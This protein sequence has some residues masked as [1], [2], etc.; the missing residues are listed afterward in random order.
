M[1]KNY[2][3]GGDNIVTE[4]FRDMLYNLYKKGRASWDD[5]DKL[6]MKTISAYLPTAVKKA[7]KGAKLKVESFDLFHYAFIVPSE[8]EEEIRDDIIRPIFVQSSLISN[9]DHKDRL[10]FL[11]DIE[12]IFYNHSFERGENTILCRI[13]HDKGKAVIKFDLI[14]TT[15]T[16]FNFPNARFFPKVTK[17]GSVS[18]TADDIEGHIKEFLRKK[19]FSVATG[20]DRHMEPLKEF[21]KIELVSLNQDSNIE[22][23]I[24]EIMSCISF[25][26]LVI[27]YNLI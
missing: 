6:L 17:S 24:K 16:L 5:E 23:V 8:W 13:S 19:L 2:E 3:K 21:S 15:N 1:A 14:Q 4:N 22:T 9:E 7:M 26:S 18:V 27:T 10:L 11:S 25:I 20:D 12:S